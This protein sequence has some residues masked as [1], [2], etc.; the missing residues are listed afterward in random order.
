M[1]R[2]VK[3]GAVVRVA[4]SIYV[5][6]KQLSS[7]PG[8]TVHTSPEKVARIW[9]KLRGYKL[10]SQGLEAAYNVGFQKQALIHSIMD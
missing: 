10:T 9:A 7:I 2:I 6:P 1:S 5:R 3:D 8:I 4:R